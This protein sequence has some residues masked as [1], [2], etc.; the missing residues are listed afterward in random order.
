MQNGNLHNKIEHKSDFLFLC[1]IIILYATFCGIYIHLLLEYIMKIILFV[2]VH[3]LFIFSL[4]F[5]YRTIIHNPSL[6]VVLIMEAKSGCLSSKIRLK[7][8]KTI[9]PRHILRTLL[10]NTAKCFSVSALLC[11]AIM[12]M[13]RMPFKIHILSL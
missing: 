12:T 11:F 5:V 7:T 2:H 8:R 3:Q 6:S 10:R 13:P 9:Y 1:P 4:Q